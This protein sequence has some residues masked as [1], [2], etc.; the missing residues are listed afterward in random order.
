MIIYHYDK[1]T[2]ELLGTGNADVDQKQSDNYLIPAYATPE[3]PLE[4][5][6]NTV[7]AYLN[8]EGN[9]PY[10]HEQGAWHLVADH[11]GY[12]GYDEAG[13]EHEITE[14]GIEPDETWTLTPPPK[15]FDFSEALQLK[16]AELVLAYKHAMTSITA[17]YTTEDIASF[18]TQ[19]AEAKA[20]DADNE[21]ETPLIDYMLDERP[22]VDK[23][24]LVSRILQN[25]V[26]YKQIAGPAIGKKQY[27]EDQLYALKTQ[28]EDPEQP[29]VTQADIDAIVVDFS[30]N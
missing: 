20:W 19:E 16:I 25:A 10:Q 26:T 17:N 9:A 27:L 6:P 30:T 4:V 8:T 15:P 1:T 12:V 5:L 22:T 18:P 21:A 14:I 29:D 7:A 23:P 28:H 13:V 11:R 2:G 3:P 24:T